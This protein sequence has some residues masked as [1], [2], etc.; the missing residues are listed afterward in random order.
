M[1]QPIAF[2]PKTNPDM[3]LAS[4]AEG[5]P[6]SNGNAMLLDQPQGE[7]EAALNPIDA[8]EGEKA[9]I[10]NGVIYAIQSGECFRR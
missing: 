6:R 5:A 7:F 4:R 8:N 3:P 2:Q 9:S 1:T 10:G